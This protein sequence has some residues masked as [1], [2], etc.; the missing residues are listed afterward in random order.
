M[1]G[2][3]GLIKAIGM[4][5]LMSVF[6]FQNAV[7]AE[8]PSS[9]ATTGAAQTEAAELPGPETGD[10]VQGQETLH[11]AQYYLPVFETSDIHGYLA[12]LSGD[13][14]K[15]LL[16]YIS[17][18][19]QD[20]RNGDLSRAVLLDGGDIYQGNTMSNL[21]KGNSL[22]AAYAM[23]GYDAVTIG[24]HEFDWLIENTVDSDGTM[25]DYDLGD[26]AGANTIPVV[27]SNLYRNGEKVPFA[28][29]YVI[30][31]KTAV[32]DEGHE[33]PVRIGV[34]GL[35]SEYDHNIMYDKFTGAGYKLIL[36]FDQVN[37]LAAKLEESG[38]CD[39]TIV[40]AHEEAAIV[41]DGLGEGTV[42]DLVLGGH[43]HLL[44]SETTSWGLPY[45]EPGLHGE[46]YAYLQLAF[47]EID[48]APVFQEVTDMD[49]I[50]VERL[51]NN[52]ENEAELDQAIV[53]LTDEA[54]DLISGVLEVKIGYITES[55][56]R[57][58]Y[59]PGSGDRAS[60]CGNW[61]SS[62]FARI[63]G[64]DVGIV[65][66]GG[67]RTDLPLEEGK[68]KRM[69][70]RSDIYTMFPFNNEIYC[71]ELTYEEL[72]TV[73][74]YGLTKNGQTR[75]SYLSGIDCYYTD[76]TVNAI[77]TK[78]G[79]AVYV[80]GAWKDGWKDKPLRVAICDYAATSDKPDNGLS[81]PFVA[82]V[83]TYR[84]IETDQID[85]LGAIDVLTA[86]AEAN[87]GYLFIDT[88]PHF[89]NRTYSA[90]TPPDN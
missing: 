57:D 90:V 78:D 55:V 89:I 42:V 73:L 13:D 3:K 63:V 46:A 32:D 27:I 51:T 6:L 31:Q 67:L 80:N 41:A 49:V 59:L 22:S 44:I 52:A 25:K 4:I 29:D 11:D 83:G 16:A 58:T 10:Q 5:I 33:M 61:C 40:L 71:F 74:K 38:Q 87:D 60:T 66:E 53:S 24:N 88:T 17:D 39:A 65:N 68:D 43:A 2:K 20:V 62:I 56:L 48:G 7:L 50:S 77:V 69:I 19:V 82:W 9:D 21:L 54:I 12:D 34:I 26:T 37:A 30:L 72:L 64:A 1:F 81:N 15:Y 45:M 85:N 79:E 86:E 8:N 18:K 14:V 35:A 23:M 76:Q 47:R 75:I 84:Q 70:T 28:R 36:D